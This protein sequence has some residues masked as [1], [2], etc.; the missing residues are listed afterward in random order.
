M[1][2]VSGRTGLSHIVSFFVLF[3]ALAFAA[4][5]AG[6]QDGASSYQVTDVQ[7]DV[8]A[9][10]AVQARETAISRGQREALDILFRRMTLKEDHARLPALN[11]A[12][13]AGLV[14]TIGFQ[15]ERYS[16]TRYVAEL[17]ISF[18]ADAIRALLRAR[19]VPYAEAL[20]RPVVV[21]PVYQ[22]GGVQVLWD[23]P[24]DWRTAWAQND[25][26]TSLLPFIMPEGSL[27]DA[28]SISIFEALSG[29][30]A[31]LDRFSSRYGT[32]EVLVPFAQWTVDLATGEPVLEID[33]RLHGVGGLQR[34]SLKVSQRNGEEETVFLKRA[35][36]T[37]SDTLATT[38]KQRAMVSVGQQQE[39]KAIADLAGLDDLM[40]LK[41]RLAQAPMVL[42]A[43]IDS[44]STVRAVL[45]L[46]ITGD[47][48]QVSESLAQYGID[49][50][51]NGDRWQLGLRQ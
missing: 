34:W 37:V 23:D 24:N 6:A 48:E 49:L 10:T 32:S 40:A 18:K 3:A 5:P 13:I 15:N 25:L 12:E 33:I 41:K 36:K 7:V 1:T 38:W 2:S 39:I 21:L 26:R 50:T 43:D 9:A 51:Q 22:D 19:D 47:A 11:G 46:T 16:T 31:S 29:N 44:L 27:A 17:T 20:G 28:S 4:G 42:K 14:D 8:T 35:A 30:R 45:A